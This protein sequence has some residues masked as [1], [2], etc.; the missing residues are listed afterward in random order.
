MEKALDINK[1]KL[2]RN[3]KATIA[4]TI[5]LALLGS[6]YLIMSIFFGFASAKNYGS[7]LSASMKMGSFSTL[8]FAVCLAIS[9]WKYRL[10]FLIPILFQVLN[11]FQA[12]E[13]IKSLTHSPSFK[14]EE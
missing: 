10:I 8:L 4:L 12:L 1:T 9:K 2:T 14:F 6:V 13:R 3:E 5:A 7:I 11:A